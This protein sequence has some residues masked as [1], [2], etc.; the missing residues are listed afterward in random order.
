M[1]KSNFRFRIGEM[2]IQV[3]TEDQE[4]TELLSR[5]IAD[6]SHSLISKPS[7]GVAEFT[8][9][10]REELLSFARGISKSMIQGMTMVQGLTSVEKKPVVIYP[11]GLTSVILENFMSLNPGV[12]FKRE[13]PK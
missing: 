9:A 13:E 6:M 4:A 5:A 1:T 8:S 10:E 7:Q 2:D 12:I 3:D 11:R